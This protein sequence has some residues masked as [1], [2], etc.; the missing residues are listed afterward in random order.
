MKSYF[1]SE[2]KRWAYFFRYI[3]FFRSE[4]I[5]EKVFGEECKEALDALR[6]DDFS[7]EETEQYWKEYAAENIVDRTE[8]LAGELF[9]MGLPKEEIAE[10]TG[11]SIERVSEIEM[12][13]LQKGLQALFFGK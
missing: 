13:R 10:A 4:R 2:F 12:E 11:L 8:E 1:N 3:N 6:L 7:D 9:L 5:A